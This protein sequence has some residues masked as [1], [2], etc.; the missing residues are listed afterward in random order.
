VRKTVFILAAIV[1]IS[2][3]TVSA[4]FLGQMSP[5]SILAPNTAKVGG[6]FV[7]AEDAFALVGSFRYG[8]GPY[9]EGRFRLGFIDQEGPHTDPHIIM[10]VD[11]KFQLWQFS[12]GT[13]GE[14]S[15]GYRNP[16]DLSVGATMEYATLQWY[17]VLGIGGSVIASR[18]FYFQNRTSIEPYGRIN[19]RYQRNHADAYYF[20]DHRYDGYS[21]S[22]FEIGLNIG[23]LFSVTPLVDFTAEFQIDDQTAFMLGIDIAAF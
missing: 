16:I 1:L 21:D 15:G 12:E 2:A 18:P 3:S 5:A 10:G 17:D 7:T 20:E 23:A 11:A 22:D 9:T 13:T 6:Y 14:A 8:F 19:L 4:Q